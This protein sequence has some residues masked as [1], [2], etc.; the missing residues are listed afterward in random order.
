MFA[1]SILDLDPG[2][3]YEARFVMSDPDGIAGQKAA[4][5]TKIIKVKTPITKAKKP[6]LPS[7]R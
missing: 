4:T 7:R 2:T 6:N 5:L 3:S 1:G